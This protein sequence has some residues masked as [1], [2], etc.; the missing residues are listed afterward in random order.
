VEQENGYEIISYSCGGLKD[1]VQ[2][3]D[4][5]ELGHCWPSSSGANSDSAR[6]YCG[7][8]SL[9]YTPVVLN[10][11]AKWDLKSIAGGSG[12]KNWAA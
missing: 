2:H 8:R 10:F 12:W 4:V 11:F 5:F 9:D 1:V 6:S 7:D 3:Y